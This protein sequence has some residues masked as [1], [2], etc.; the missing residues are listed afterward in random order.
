MSS[1]CIHQHMRR[2]FSGAQLLLIRDPDPD[3]DLSSSG[4]HKGSVAVLCERLCAE[5]GHWHCL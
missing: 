4:S 3:R 1:S 5:V 2:L